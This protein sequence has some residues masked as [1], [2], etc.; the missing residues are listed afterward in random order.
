MPEVPYILAAVAVAASITWLLR[1]LPFAL[2]APLQESR[3]LPY[4]GDRLAVGVMV[5]L[6]IYTLQGLDLLRPSVAV[7]A[8]IALAVTAGL[9]LWR[10]SMVLSLV[11]GTLTHVV[12]ASAWPG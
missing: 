1:A 8:A 2:L 11:A 12:L 6:V 3:L 10:G 5:I 7:P 4:L 9:H